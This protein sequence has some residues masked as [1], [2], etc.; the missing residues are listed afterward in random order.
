MKN[1]LVLLAFAAALAAC[2]KG[3]APDPDAASGFGSLAV[4][5]V[6][7]PVV[8]AV[9]RAQVALPAGTEIP[10][11]R[12]MTMRIVNPTPGIEY[13][14]AWARVANYNKKTDQ[15]P[16]GR[17]YTVTIFSTSTWREDA[18]ENKTNVDYVEEGVDKPYFE[19]VVSDVAIERRK[20]TPVEIKA[21]LANTIVR[22]EFSDT[23]RNYFAG[24]ATF[25]LRTAA[26][27][28]FTTGYEAD[29]P[30][31]AE[32]Y[33]YVRPAAFTISGRATKQTPSATADPE[34]VQFREV[35]NSA[36]QPTTLY[37]YR[38]DITGVGGTEGVEITL[39][40]QPVATETI[41]EELNPD[42]YI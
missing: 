2:S 13:G 26:G 6:C 41:D 32:T 38:F 9:T 8:E 12:E 27:N 30:T 22:I 37:T 7:E 15:L 34:T 1:T 35:V 17:G 33:W 31:V 18:K 42:S 40:G 11:W 19:G 24:G 14:R 20:E 4:E 5:A 16:E 36:V 3:D 25:T 29:D 39:N 28:A 21:R 23:F 10:D